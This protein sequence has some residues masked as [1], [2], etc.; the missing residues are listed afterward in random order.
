MIAINVS[1]VIF[2]FIDM[3]DERVNALRHRFIW[4]CEGE[5]FKEKLSVMFYFV[6]DN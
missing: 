1:L 2:I 6:L 4:I 5:T 3:V